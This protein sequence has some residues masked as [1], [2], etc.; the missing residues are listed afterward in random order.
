MSQLPLVEPSTQGSE[1]P[2]K[3]GGGD[4]RVARKYQDI[5]NRPK[6]VKRRHFSRDSTAQPVECLPG[7]T[8]RGSGTMDSSFESH[9]CLLRM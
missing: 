7:L 1:P 5:C 4:G 8:L 2:E 9:Q 3:N 6:I